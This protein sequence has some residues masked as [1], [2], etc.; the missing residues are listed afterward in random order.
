MLWLDG[1]HGVE[2]KGISQK[3]VRLLQGGVTDAGNVEMSLTYYAIAQ[4]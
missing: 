3:D 1:A 4:K 2:T